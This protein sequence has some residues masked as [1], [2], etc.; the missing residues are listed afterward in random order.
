[1]LG[2]TA[3]AI[4]FVPMFF[5]VLEKLG[6]GKSG[7]EPDAGAAGDSA[8]RADAPVRP[9]ATQSPAGKAGDE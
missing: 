2:A 5:L 3:V 6:I 1:M 7:A 8:A 4:F 9:E